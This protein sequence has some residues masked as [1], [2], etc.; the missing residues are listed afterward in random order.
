MKTWGDRLRTVGGAVIIVL[1]VSW[2]L[3]LVASEYIGA[4]WPRSRVID[5]AE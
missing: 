4:F 5:S 1:F 3:V 2:A